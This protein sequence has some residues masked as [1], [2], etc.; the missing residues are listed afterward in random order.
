[1]YMYVYI[2]NCL[3]VSQ[4]SALTCIPALRVDD[5]L[6]GLNG[7]TGLSM[8]SMAKTIMKLEENSMVELIIERNET[9]TVSK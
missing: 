6:I 1:M 5:I 4:I 2:L 7:V 3:Y 8:R 9:E